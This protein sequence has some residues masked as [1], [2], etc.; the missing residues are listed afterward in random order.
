MEQN[1]SMETCANIFQSALRHLLFASLLFLIPN[2]SYAQDKSADSYRLAAEQGDAEAQY[3]LGECYYRGRG[4]VEQSNPEAFSW[5]TKAADQDYA[6]AIYRI[7][8]CYEYGYGV[9]KD[10]NKA[11][12]YFQ[13]AA[14]MNNAD[15]I[16]E[17]GYCYENALGGL[18]KDK[19]K[20]FELYMK[21]AEMGQ[22][23]AMRNVGNCYNNGIGV[24][25]DKE[26][27]FKWCLKAAEAGN[28]QAC[29]D[30]GYYYKEKKN[31]TE[32]LKWYKKGATQGQSYCLNQIG[33]M[34]SEGQIGS[35]KNDAKAA[36]W[37]LLAD[38]KGSENSK[39]VLFN[40]MGVQIVP[41]A[42]GLNL[43]TPLDLEEKPITGTWKCLYKKDDGQYDEAFFVF[44]TNGTFEVKMDMSMNDPTFIM[45]FSA[46][47]G[48]T[49][50]KTAYGGI[51]FTANRQTAR[52]ST[53]FDV[54]DPNMNSAMKARL[55]E[56]VRPYLSQVE[57]G[58]KEI[59]IQYISML[60]CDLYACNS[61]SLVLQNQSF[62]GGNVNTATTILV[63]QK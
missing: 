2:M 30:V 25:Q 36:M 51:S 34:Y 19:E 18:S 56:Q 6:P 12:K 8:R 15:A 60:Q 38:W 10:L 62:S 33:W 29:G 52:V 3:Q 55:R 37:H 47:M 46:K 20:A 28:Y 54:T 26:E 48:G 32:A 40:N 17:L 53:S 39:N 5:F 58:I 63:R 11:V 24:Q 1:K 21:A 31:Y 22:N 9:G 61:Y 35:K 41:G 27:G 50:K 16:L 59:L 57:S 14:D 23:I 43:S 49:Y 7:G 44:R 13:R 45:K 42:A 4:G